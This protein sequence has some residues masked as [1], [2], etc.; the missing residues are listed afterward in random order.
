MFYNY[1]LS[2]LNLQCNH[3]GKNNSKINLC[4][5]SKEKYSIKSLHRISEDEFIYFHTKFY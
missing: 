5:L 4:T 2:K 1:N 3:V